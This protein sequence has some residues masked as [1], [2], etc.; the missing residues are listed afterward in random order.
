M[1]VTQIHLKTHL[2]EYTE[3]KDFAD[4]TMLKLTKRLKKVT[5]TKKIKVSEEHSN[6]VNFSVVCFHLAGRFI[7]LCYRIELPIALQRIL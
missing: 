6:V 7:I 2:Q 1:N 4:L 3:K 5:T